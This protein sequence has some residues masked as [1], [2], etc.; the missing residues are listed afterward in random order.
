VDFD[1]DGRVDIVVTS[2]DE[3]VELLRNVSDPKQNWLDL[4]LT[5]TRSNRDAIGAT[6][7]VTTASGITQTNHVTTSVGY[8]SSSSR[9]VHFGLGREA[10]AVQVEIRWPSGRTQTLTDM[11]PGQLLKVSEPDR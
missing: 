5:G 3:P 9:R 4:L 6:V 7:R 10:A 11:K 8:A 1:N 2:L